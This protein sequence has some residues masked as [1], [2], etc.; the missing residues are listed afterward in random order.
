M[1]AYGSELG[2]YDEEKFRPWMLCRVLSWG[3]RKR[4]CGIKF[5][6]VAGRSEVA[7]GMMKCEA[8]AGVGKKQ[9]LCDCLDEDLACLLAPLAI[10][11]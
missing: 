11:A 1:V 9:E 3:E 5:R 10:S 8:G 4:V 7:S 2:R 6:E